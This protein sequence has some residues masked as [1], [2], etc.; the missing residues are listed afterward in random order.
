MKPRT[1]AVLLMAITLVTVLRVASTY[2]VFNDTIDESNHIEAGLEYWQFGRYSH[3]PQHP[4]LARIVLAALPYHLGELR[5]G[6]KR[7][8]PDGRIYERPASEPRQP[9]EGF[10]WA[11]PWR[12]RSEQYY[13]RTLSLARAGNLIFLVALLAVV[14]FWVKDLFDPLTALIASV[15][16]ACSPTVLGHAG[17]ATLDLAVATNV[18]A[19]S[20][21]WWRWIGSRGRF[22][23]VGAGVATA[24]AIAS[25]FSALVFLPPIVA[26]YLWLERRAL[27]DLLRK[28]AGRREMSMQSGFLIVALS[29]SLWG[30][31][32]FDFG[33]I[34]APG[35]TYVSP[36]ERGSPSAIARS[37]AETI[38]SFPVPAPA[39]LQGIIDVAAH[40]DQGHASYLLGE[41]SQTGRRAYFPIAIGLKTTL[42]LLFLTIAAIAVGAHDPRQRRAM[43]TLGSPALVVVAVAMAAD[44][45]IGIRHILPVYPSLAMVAACGFTC[46]TGAWRPIRLGA[47]LLACLFVWHVGES[48]AAHPDYLP[49]F[50]EIAGGREHH[51]LADSN[52]D[53]GQDLKR[54]SQWAKERDIAAMTVRYFG[55]AFPERFGLQSAV[56]PAAHP[57]SGWFAISTNLLFG[58]EGNSDKLRQLAATEP[59]IKVGK[60]IWVYRIDRQDLGELA[61]PRFFERL[62]RKQEGF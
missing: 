52:V 18:L 40:N 19:S 46:M 35:T 49:Y 47:A 11:G 31:Y 8:D 21:F 48:V 20:Y 57:D 24:L 62:V 3:E 23:A 12:G 4:P 14:Y 17:L 51:Y 59:E 44:I 36:E 53:W 45:N 16:A 7:I 32:G 38:G 61:P 9:L 29:F 6:S 43:L 39:L 5:L 28:T 50:N 42:P 54:L 33:P 30:L 2:A 25:K 58:L 13:W 34:S 55:D 10:S 60:S 56:L 37:I 1:G 27:V 22:N 26:I 15:L 41:W